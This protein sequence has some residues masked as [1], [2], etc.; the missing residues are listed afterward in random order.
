MTIVAMNSTSFNSQTRHCSQFE[1]NDVAQNVNHNN[2]TT[3]LDDT[4]DW[5]AMRFYAVQEDQN[6]RT[7]AWTAYQHP[8]EHNLSSNTDFHKNQSLSTSKKRKR[9]VS[10]IGET[11]QVVEES[12]NAP[13]VK[14]TRRN[15][16]YSTDANDSAQ[17]VTNG[18]L[19]DSI[20]SSNVDFQEVRDILSRS[21]PTL[22]NPSD[23]VVNLLETN[24]YADEQLS[25]HPRLT[26]E[27]DPVILPKETWVDGTICANGLVKFRLQFNNDKVPQTA[28]DTLAKYRSANENNRCEPSAV[29]DVSYLPPDF[30]R[31]LRFDE[32]DMRLFKFCKYPYL[33]LLI[34]WERADLQDRY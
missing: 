26:S 24:P 28:K 14:R 31:G 13:N 33:L 7:K 3:Q 27:S 29:G 17:H 30:G 6:E 18:F 4:F 1:D 10:D 22:P 12:S 34:E 23:R 5:E 15:T 9:R 19:E 8:L 32:M 2:D 16:N 25:E 11:R 20:A 21:N